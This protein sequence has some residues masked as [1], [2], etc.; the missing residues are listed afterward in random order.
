MRYKKWIVFVLLSYPV[1]VK[2]GI[3]GD[4]NEMFMSN[5]TASGQ[6]NTKD[7]VGVFG[8]SVAIRAPVRSVVVVAFDPPRLNA[9]CGGVDLYGGSF[10]MINSQQLVQI[11]RQVAAH[12]AS[13]A[14]KAAIKAISPSLDA[15]MTEFQSLLQNMN[16]LAKNSCQ[17]AHLVIDPAE[18]T[19]TNALQ[20][21]GNVGATNKGMFTDAMAS[22]TGYLASANSYFKKQGEVNPKSGN[23]VVK[24]VTASGATNILG[25]AGLKNFDGSDDD[26]SD[27]NTL[28]N[29]LL[30][31]FLGYEI[32]GVP[33]DSSNEAGQKDTSPDVS[34]NSLTRLSCKGSA[35]LK[36]DDMVKGGGT[37]SIRAAT[38]LTLYKCVNPAGSGIANGGFDPQICTHMQKESF[39]YYGIQGWINQMMFGSATSD[40]VKPDSIL[41]KVNGG[42]TLTFTTAQVQ[43]IKNSGIPL[44][45]LL[46]KT[47]N[48]STRVSIAQRLGSYLSDCIAARFGEGLYK[49]ANGIQYNNHYALSDDIK[50]NIETLRVD[51]MEMQKACVKDATVLRIAQELNASATLNGNTK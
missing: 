44:I 40:T 23:Q 21:D 5:S 35:T 14:F 13:L 6:I 47:S 18:K 12:A 24:A 32:F 31:S 2:A 26:A 46:S 16:N 48:P 43:F 7:R 27:P 8:G 9:G 39:T 45:S 51:Y 37:G 38:P 49:A 20:G 28:N 10:S 42:G 1:F 50:K 19:L 22:L 15:L 29:K 11:F 4:L 25:L 17:L 36:L 41:G 3:L 33:C 30:I 34:S